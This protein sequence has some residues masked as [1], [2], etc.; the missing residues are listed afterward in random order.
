[1]LINLHARPPLPKGSGEIRRREPDAPR[2]GAA[3]ARPSAA[4][5]ATKVN[6]PDAAAGLLKALIADLRGGAAESG[7]LF[8]RAD[9]ARIAALLDA[10]GASA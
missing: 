9:G 1:M 10:E 6:D 8:A 3:D 4:A 5:T 2:P 7:A